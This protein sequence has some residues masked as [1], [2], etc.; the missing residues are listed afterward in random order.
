MERDESNLY[1]F[2]EEEYQEAIDFL[3]K[4][5]IRDYGIF[6]SL[7][8]VLISYRRRCGEVDHVCN[9]V[10]ALLAD[11]QDLLQD[12]YT[13]FI[14][15][16]KA[17]PLA[18]HVPIDD[19]STEKAWQE[20]NS[21]EEK[22][23]EGFHKQVITFFGKVHKKLPS[24]S[25]VEFLRCF[26]NYSSQRIEKVE[27]EKSVAI[28]IGEY[29]ELMAAFNLFLDDCE[30]I[31]G[32]S[33]KKIEDDRYELD[34]LMSWLKSAASY[35]E[36]SIKGNKEIGG[37]SRTQFLRS[38]ERLYGDQGLEMLEIWQENP[39][40]ASTVILVRLMQKIE[41]LTN[42]KIEMEKIWAQAYIVYLGSL[43]EGE[44]SPSAQHLSLLQAVVDASFLDNSLIR[45]YKRSF[46]GFAAKLTSLDFL[47]LYLYRGV[48]GWRGVVSVFPSR[49]F[50]VRTTRSWN[51]MG[52][53]EN[54]TQNHTVE[55]DTIVGVIDTGLW[56]E[57]ASFSDEGFGPAP[58][59]WKGKCEGGKN[60]T[61]NKRHCKRRGT[62]C[63][64]RSY[65]ACQSDGSCQGVDIL[66]AFDDAIVD[67]VDI[68]TVSLGPDFAV[69][70]P[71]DEISVGSFHAIEKGILTVNSAGNSGPT[72][73]TVATV[74]LWMLAVAASSIDCG[75]ID[76]VVLGNGKTL[77]GSSVNSFTL[78]GAKFP[79]VYGT[80]ASSLY[81]VVGARDDKRRV[82]Y[83]VLSGTSMSCP[84][85]AGV[86][87]YV[88]T[89]H[90]DWSPSAI[91]STIMT[92][93]W[94][95][96]P[97]ENSDAEFAYGSGHLNPLEAINPG[98]VDE[99][100]KDDCKTVVQH[101]LFY[102]DN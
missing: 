26:Y 55:S 94:C 44:Y 92:T 73:G 88:K 37:M 13:G 46:N 56:P 72:A 27:L 62:F 9:E 34:M 70:I 97:A 68:I 10:S 11:H 82:E 18:Y 4:V 42:F 45:S 35:V 50:R 17:K 36:E 77:I 63:Q 28:H 67:G 7:L 6:I 102:R 49:T 1:Y 75:F 59:K 3:N 22:P 58:K 78:N 16:S 95:V 54:I 15:V 12:F 60:F 40:P 76:K 66:A 31:D 2:T 87:A 19:G 74:A 101:R 100:L 48:Q 84:H 80:N 64:N 79:L 81:S 30:N 69:D 20:E 29:P 32:F 51:F 96:N 90:P 24:Q 5:Q 83:N 65:K 57:S 86:A 98:L 89:F 47:V 52:F 33:R 23:M 71:A 8:E 39:K 38:V 91:K 85:A 41:E 21:S 53:Q 99:A 25:Y 14:S 61:C 93:A 43:P